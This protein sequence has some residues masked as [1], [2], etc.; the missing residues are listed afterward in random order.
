MC[1]QNPDSECEAQ[2]P[3]G[4]SPAMQYGSLLLLLRP[5]VGGCGFGGSRLGQQVLSWEE[6][7]L[8]CAELSH[9]CK[10]WLEQSQAVWEGESLLL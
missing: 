8:E 4:T 1:F 9:F 2:E 7:A 6:G 5:G 10:F 3:P